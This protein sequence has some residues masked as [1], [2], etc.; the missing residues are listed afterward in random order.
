MN[1]DALQFVCKKM[2]GVLKEKQTIESGKKG[3]TTLPE[4]IWG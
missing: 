2:S 1:D 3:Q 4:R